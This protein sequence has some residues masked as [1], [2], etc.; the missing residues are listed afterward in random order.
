MRDLIE[1]RRDVGLENP[2]VV[3]RG[4]SEEVN[5]GDRVMSAAV[6]AKAV[7]TRLE[8][9]LEH[10]LE[11]QLQHACT[12]RSAAVA[13]PRRRNL[14]D[15]FEISFSRTLVGVYRRAFRPSRMPSRNSPPPGSIDRGAI[16]SNTGRACALVAPD[17]NWPGATHDTPQLATDARSQT[18]AGPPMGVPSDRP[19]RRRGG[20]VPT[21]PVQMGAPLPRRRGTKHC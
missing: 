11:H 6:R 19:R 16:P 15:A 2:L 5:L 14:P 1:A 8:V 17:P 9:R 3:A 12:T 20:C 21:V 4:R 7:G 10:R 18:A 13:I